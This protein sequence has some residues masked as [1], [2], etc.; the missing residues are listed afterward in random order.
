MLQKFHKNTPQ[1]VGLIKATLAAMKLPPAHKN[2][3]LAALLGG[4]KSP[5]SK[6][7]GNLTDLVF[8]GVARPKRHQPGKPSQKPHLLAA[9]VDLNLIINCKW[10]MAHKIESEQSNDAHIQFPKNLPAG[11]LILIS[12]EFR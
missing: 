10:V 12:K 4:E 9:I 7:E 6:K 3:A 5:S 1:T 2:Y 8:P 11:P